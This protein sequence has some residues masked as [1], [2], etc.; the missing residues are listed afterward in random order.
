MTFRIKKISSSQ[1]KKG[2][3]TSTPE[4]VFAKFISTVETSKFKPRDHSM[5]LCFGVDPH[6][7]D[8]LSQYRVS[9]PGTPGVRR[10]SRAIEVVDLPFT[11]S[12]VEP[13][14]QATINALL[15]KDMALL[16]FID[17]LPRP[18]DMK[19]A[20]ES[21]EFDDE[22]RLDP[23]LRAVRDLGIKYNLGFLEIEF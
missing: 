22:L 19:Q 16:R 1:F 23:V 2:A 14:A 17:S 8:T 10:L 7:P 20:A 4:R 18:R 12:G 21:P 9:F 15:E 11:L 3:A 13:I 5:H 6:L